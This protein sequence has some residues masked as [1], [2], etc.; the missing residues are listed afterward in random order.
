MRTAPIAAVL[1]G[2]RSPP[3]ADRD[4]QSFPLPFLSRFNFSWM[5]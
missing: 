4:L 2:R 3:T 5:S 1:H